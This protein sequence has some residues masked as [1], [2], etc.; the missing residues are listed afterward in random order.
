MIR[1]WLAAP[2]LIALCSL[3]LVGFGHASHASAQV[4]SF[5]RLQALLVTESDISDTGLSFLDDETQTLDG[6]L[7]QV[8]RTFGMAVPG[9][10]AVGAVS[11]VAS[12]DGSAPP[13][14]VTNM[15]AS[16]DL[17]KAM[18]Q[19][20][21]ASITSFTLTGSQGVGDLDQSVSF[22]GVLNG[23]NYRFYGDSFVSGNL[24]AMV[25]Y[26]APVDVASP[27]DALTML[28]AQDDKLP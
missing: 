5:G 2:A 26:G 14:S 9:G 16:G 13:T 20:T 1:K 24:V 27:D 25:L 10:A 23:A 7:L 18:A 22:D 15:V 28:H 12:P 11:L 3:F 4:Y 21:G 19:G 8:I 17:L 6:G